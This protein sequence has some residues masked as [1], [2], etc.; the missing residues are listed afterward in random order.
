[1]SDGSVIY[2]YISTSNGIRVAGLAPTAASHAK[3]R[4]NM[5]VN[6]RSYGYGGDIKKVNIRMTLTRLLTYSASTQVSY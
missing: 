3:N 2:N 6:N 1:M 5:L 4:N